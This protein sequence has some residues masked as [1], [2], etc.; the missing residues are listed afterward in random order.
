MRSGGY[1]TDQ[2]YAPPIEPPFEQPPF[3]EPLSQPGPDFAPPAPP[4]RPGDLNPAPSAAL[5]LREE[6]P[7]PPSE[8]EESVQFLFPA[9]TPMPN[10]LYPNES[11]PILEQ[12]SA[13]RPS[14]RQPK[15][16]LP[17]GKIAL[18]MRGHST[19]TTSEWK[20]TSLRLQ[21]IETE[22][23][24]AKLMQVQFLPRLAPVPAL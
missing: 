2:V 19:F 22:Q 4:A 5:R 18:N 11:K 9:P 16:V 12:S 15:E 7:A 17:E 10:A 20:H 3:Q 14:N 8:D 13:E 23:E 6:V 1:A 21:P 24:P